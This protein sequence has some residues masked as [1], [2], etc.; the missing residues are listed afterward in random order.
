MIDIRKVYT[1]VAEFIYKICGLTLG[2]K[3]HIGLRCSL[4]GVASIKIGESSYIGND[5]RLACFNN[6]GKSP[7]LSIG[8]RT[9][10]TNGVNILC[11]ECITIGNDCMFAAYS[12]IVDEDHGTDLSLGISYEE[13]PL[14][15]SP[16]VIGNNVW[17]G[18]KA[19]ILKG[20]TIGDN[21]IIGANA[22]VKKDIPRNC[23]AVGNPARVVKRWES[24]RWV[25]CGG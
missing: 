3:S 25:R 16:V 9:L 13:Q 10:L 24:G 5:T 12:S 7:Q 6:C 19:C 14:V 11:A 2:K 4:E 18:Q 17:V 22:V 1:R 20:V 23:I 15:T 8:D 21:C